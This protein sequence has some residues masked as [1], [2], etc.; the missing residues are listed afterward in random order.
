MYLGPT[1]RSGIST[2]ANL[3]AQE[4]IDSGCRRL[5]HDIDNGKVHAVIQEYTS[6]LGDYAFFH[7]GSE[8]NLVPRVIGERMNIQLRARFLLHIRS[9]MCNTQ[10]IVISFRLRGGR[11]SCM[12]LIVRSADFTKAVCH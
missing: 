3:A 4:E 11:R 1:V 8:V 9:V 10:D 12:K 2:F 6:I 7:C 5:R